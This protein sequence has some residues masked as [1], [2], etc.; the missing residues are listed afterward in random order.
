AAVALLAV[1]LNLF[2]EELY[3]KRGG[4]GQ[5]KDWANL[6]ASKFRL[7]CA[8]VVRITYRTRVARWDINMHLT[9]FLA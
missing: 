4:R 1:N 9:L 6:E 7:L 5:V 3:K 2:P 8:H